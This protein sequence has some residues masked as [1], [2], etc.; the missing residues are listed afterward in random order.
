MMVVQL[1]DEIFYKR[2]FSLNSHDR[3][4][5]VHKRYQGCS[6]GHQETGIPGGIFPGHP[7]FSIVPCFFRLHW[8]PGEFLQELSY[9]NGTNSS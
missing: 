7:F 1:L 6:A 3:H 9:L 2:S 4:A 8:S 5:V